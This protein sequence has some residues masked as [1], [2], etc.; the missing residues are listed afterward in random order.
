MWM[1]TYYRQLL[2]KKLNFYIYGDNALEIGCHDGFLLHNINSKK[3]TGIDLAP[4]N[5]YPEINYIKSDFIVHDF[6]KGKFDFILSIEVLEHVKD[7]DGFIKKLD[8]L[9]NVKGKAILSVPSKNIKIF[10]YIFQSYLNKRWGHE[11]RTGFTYEQ[12]KNLLDKHISK[13]YKI[14]EWN[15]PFFRTSYLSLKFLWMLF[16]NLTKKILKV[17]IDIDSKFKKGK[18]GYFFILIN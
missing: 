18:H 11:Y 14:I 10:P 5:K 9:L 7:P 3:K 6:K 16:P 2:L 8:K 15:C 13:N 4:L 17:F 12:L 1:G